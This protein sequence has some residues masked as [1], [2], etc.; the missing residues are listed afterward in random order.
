MSNLFFSRW[1]WLGVMIIGVCLGVG[2]LGRYT[3]QTLNINLI[4]AP[5]LQTIV[6]D[7]QFS[8][9]GWMAETLWEKSNA[10][11]AEG[12]YY[13][14]E[15]QRKELVLQCVALLGEISQ[16]SQQIEVAYTDPAV[17]D[18]ASASAAWQTQLAQKRAELEQLQPLAEAILQEQVAAVLL[19]E[20]FGLADQVW[21]PVQMHLTSLPSILI[22]SP[23]EEI[24]QANAV[25]LVY[26]LQVPARALMEE[27]V[28]EELGQVG[29]VT[30]I[31]GLATYPAM[32]LEV[33]HLPFLVEITAH[34][35]A[36]HWLSFHPLGLFYSSSAE[37]QTI[38]ETVASIFGKEV[39]AAVLRRYYPEFAPPPQPPAPP[40]N[41]TPTPPPAPAA[42]D[43][44][45][46]M[47]QTRVVVDAMLTAG[48][49]EAAEIYMQE[50]RQTFVQKGYNLRVLNQA[51]FAFHGSYAD[52][53]GATGGNPIGPT[54]N[55]LR[56]QSGSLWEFMDNVAP[57]VSLVELTEVAETLTQPK[58]GE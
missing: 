25:P 18:P 46:E 51:Y 24:R 10:H 17:A 56:A 38:N 31:G 2:W 26:G 1:W 48:Q 49:I 8:F 55:Q 54:V 7:Q 12:H 34:E 30:N 50:R 15:S 42:F 6:Q 22:I 52:T 19:D 36:H 5:E 37:T 33:G 53:G 44:R 41:N 16:L 11:L 14:D 23:R 3:L 21:P 20:G 4:L 27:R 43:F 39:G 40:A 29:Y 32:I 28:F 9:T 57:V 58:E 13:L 47:Y 35:W 45:R